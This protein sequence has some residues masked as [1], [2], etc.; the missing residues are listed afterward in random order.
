MTPY[1]MIKAHLST[2]V[3]FATY[4]GVDLLDISDGQASAEL[5]QRD[6]TSNHIQSMHAAAM[7]ALGEAASGAAVAGALAPVILEMRPVAAT[8][9]IKF[10][11]VA[12]GKLTAQ[13][14]TSRPGGELMQA[15]K[16]DGKVA[17]DVTVD[18]TD[19]AGDSVVGMTVNWYVS[20][21]R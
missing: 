7:F 18:I 17:F 4:V 12:K 19:A 13:A 21:Q 9:D 6:E 14:R 16:D 15:I 8:A 5:Q 1:D 3:P 11:K 20:P 2:A 10:L